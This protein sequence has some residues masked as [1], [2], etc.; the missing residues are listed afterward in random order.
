MLLY[1][2]L[3]LIVLFLANTIQTITGFAGNLL[4]M[5]PSLLLQGY[6]TSVTVLNVFTLTA[7]G[8]IA[9]KNRIFI[10][11][12]IL[13]KMLSLML[14]GMG[15]G[16]FVISRFDLNILLYVYGGTIIL[17]AIQSLCC[18]KEPNFPTWMQ[19]TALLLSGIFHGIFVS[20]GAL[21]V[22]Y[23][24]KVLP[25]KQIFRA[26][27]SPVWV[28]LGI[29]LIWRHHENGYYT[30]RNIQLIGISMI[31][32]ILSIMIGNYLY[33]HINQPLFQKITYILVLIAGII[34]FI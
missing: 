22:I 8:W 16:I 10:Q 18:K 21:L 32:L 28:V 13:F 11:W 26:T 7:C 6:E 33:N 5:P 12:K 29:L 30:L 25:E 14:L 31:P 27:V 3:F 15:F 19:Y 20:G 2:I 34:I 23:A 17:I 1:D 4:A 24:V 9:Y